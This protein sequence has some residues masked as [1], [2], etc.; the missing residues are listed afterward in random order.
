[1]GYISLHKQYLLLSE[2]CPLFILGLIILLRILV[3]LK[4]EKKGGERPGFW[5]T[6]RKQLL[7]IA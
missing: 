2:K 5:R 7:G 6:N 4:R 3:Y 1:M